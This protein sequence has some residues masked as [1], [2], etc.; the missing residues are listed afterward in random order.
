MDLPCFVVIY[1]LRSFI[2]AA[3]TMAT[4]QVPGERQLVTNVNQRAVLV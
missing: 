4:V 1:E 2:R 3:D